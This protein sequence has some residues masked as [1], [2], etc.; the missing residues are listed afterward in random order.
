MIGHL[1]MC[2]GIK[3]NYQERELSFYFPNPKS[4]LPVLK[5]DGS[6]GLLP[7]GRREKQPGKLPL[8]GWARLESIKKSTW[9][10]YQAKPAK[11][12]IKH[13][14]EKDKEGI[15][16]WFNL[17]E[18]EYIQGLVARYGDE[19]RVYIVTVEAEANQHL[20]KRWPRIIKN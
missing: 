11:L 9:D 17:A 12:A 10:K 3:F 18:D 2:G 7:W 19:L 5:K 15:S 4:L 6:I 13:F 8:G 20:H 16:H 1:H 14:M